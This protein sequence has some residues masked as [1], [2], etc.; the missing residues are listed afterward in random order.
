MT[1]SQL[2]FFAGW[3]VLALAAG[4]LIVWAWE[5]L[6]IR[7]MGRTEPATARPPDGREA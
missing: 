4:V 6:R 2:A 7:A 5:R 1:V 3:L